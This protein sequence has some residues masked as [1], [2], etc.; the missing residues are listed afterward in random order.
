MLEKEENALKIIA[1][2]LSTDKRILKIIAYGSRVRGDFRGDSDLDVLIVVDK[3]DKE[4]KEKI[5]DIF[6]EYELKEGIPFSPLIFSIE[7]FSVNEK[8]GSP[9]IKK[10]KEE[11]VVIYD[12]DIRREKGNFKIS[13]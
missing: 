9:F 3:K 5:I 2:N 6:Y 12:I 13:S 7:E 1:E 11:G 8:I 10:I 4:I